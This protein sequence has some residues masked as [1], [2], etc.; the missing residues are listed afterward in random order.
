LRDGEDQWKQQV[1]EL[2]MYW[3]NYKGKSKWP[4]WGNFKFKKKTKRNKIKLNNF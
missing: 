3:Y 2:E 4:K 1:E